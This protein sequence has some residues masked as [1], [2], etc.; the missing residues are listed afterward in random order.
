MKKRYFYL[1]FENATKL[2]FEYDFVN[3]ADNYKINYTKLNKNINIT[4]KSPD[5]S[6]M[7]VSFNPYLYN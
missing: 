7:G 4:Q 3:I 5:D 2:S 1:Y 6:T